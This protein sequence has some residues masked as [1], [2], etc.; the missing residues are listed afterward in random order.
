[1][2]ST[3]QKLRVYETLHSLNQGFEQVL[4]DL[5][6]LQ[7]FP[8]FRRKFLRHFQVMVEETR[9]W[10]DFELLAAL[11]SREQDDWTRFGRLRRQWEKRYQ[12]PDD[13]VPSPAELK[14]KRAKPAGK[15]RTKNG[16][17]AGHD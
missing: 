6:R 14:R 4:A 5:G 11:Q 10:A 1:M 15:L 7:D 2:K 8:F 3:P 17:A 12:D 13:V 9:A 16:K